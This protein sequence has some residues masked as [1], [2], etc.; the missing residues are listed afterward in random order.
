MK[1]ALEKNGKKLEWMALSHEGHGAYN[2]ATR[3]EVYERVLKFL[4]ENLGR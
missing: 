4:D 2:E 3:R 1:S